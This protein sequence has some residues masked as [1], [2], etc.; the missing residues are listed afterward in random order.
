MYG[1]TQDW[2]SKSITQATE[3][4]L[5]EAALRNS[6]EAA[7]Y[8]NAALEEDDRDILLFNLLHGTDSGM[9]PPPRSQRLRVLVRF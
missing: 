1:V 7:A 2:I 4:L 5:Q 3:Y 6:A 9:R 8:L